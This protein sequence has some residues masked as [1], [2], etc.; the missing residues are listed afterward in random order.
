MAEGAGWTQETSTTAVGLL[1]GL[2]G[3]KENFPLHYSSENSTP[4]VI[5][6]I[7]VIIALVMPSIL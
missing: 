6:R 5:S 3:T 2:G 7:K 4:N 1:K